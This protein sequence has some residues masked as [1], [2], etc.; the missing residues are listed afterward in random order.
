MNAR[1]DMVVCAC[2]C[3]VHTVVVRSLARSLASLLRL[4]TLNRMYTRW[5]IGA[6]YTPPTKRKFTLGFT[7]FAIERTLQAESSLKTHFQCTHICIF[8]RTLSGFQFML[9]KIA[10]SYRDRQ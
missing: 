5:F 1:V 9:P 6:L 10:H 2:V 3:S 7:N 4:L 8:L